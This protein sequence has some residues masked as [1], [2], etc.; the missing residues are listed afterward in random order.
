MHF[1]PLPCLNWEV[2]TADLLHFCGRL[3]IRLWDWSLVPGWSNLHKRHSELRC[4]VVRLKSQDI[5]AKSLDVVAHMDVLEHLP[6]PVG[7]MRIALDLLK[8]DGFMLL[9]TPRF[10]PEKTYEELQ[11]SQHS[12]LTHFKELEHLFLFSKQSLV[13][14]FHGLGWD[15][16]QFEPA[17]F[18]N[19]DMFTLVSRQPLNPHSKEDQI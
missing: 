19:Y 6:D 13:K 8:P 12:F 14:F 1:P 5:P 15:H 16:V 3:V 10:E 18:S 17:I 9:Q 4:F 7:T 2:H 11:S